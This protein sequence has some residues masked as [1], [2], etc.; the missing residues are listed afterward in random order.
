VR[1]KRFRGPIGPKHRE[2][3]V[4]AFPRG[5][6]GLH[7]VSNRTDTPIRVLMVSTLIE[8]DLV[9]YPGRG[10]FGARNVKG[11][12]VF[13]KNY[14]SPQAFARVFALAI[15]F[16]V[17]RVFSPSHHSPRFGPKAQDDER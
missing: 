16:S 9:H 7:Q 10:K 11:E 17:A 12:R 14:E 4:V 13:A 15:C 6:E 3:D 2:G 5:D 1:L 8:P